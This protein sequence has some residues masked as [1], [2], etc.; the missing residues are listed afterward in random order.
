MGFSSVWHWIIVLIV[1]L[2]LFGVGR[3]PRLMGD[4]A[5]GINAFKK[6]LNEDGD[7]AAKGSSAPR[8]SLEEPGEGVVGPE[9][10]NDRDKTA[11]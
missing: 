10:R 2:L 8:A 5:K 1:V 6:G 4:V 9:T 11:S 3:I 7:E